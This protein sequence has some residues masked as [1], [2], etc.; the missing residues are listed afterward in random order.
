MAL[1]SAKT[2]KPKELGM[3]GIV[4][5]RGG[6]VKGVVNDSTSREVHSISDALV[7]AKLGL[8]ASDDRVW[9][10]GIAVFYRIFK[11]LENQCLEKAD[12]LDPRLL[13]IRIPGMERTERFEADLEFYYGPE[14]KALIEPTSPEI[15]AYI[16]HLSKLRKEEPIV[17]S[18]F[19]YHLYMGLFA[20]GQILKR[21]RRI[22][23]KV[24]KWLGGSPGAGA[25]DSSEGLEVVSFGSP[26]LDLKRA[27]RHG[28]E[29]LADELDDKSKNRILEEGINVFKLNNSIIRTIQS[30]DEVFQQRL[31][32][33]SVPVIVAVLGPRGMVSDRMV[34]QQRVRG[35]VGVKGRL[36][37]RKGG[38]TVAARLGIDLRN[39]IGKKSVARDTGIDLRD[40]IGS[41]DSAMRLNTGTQALRRPL[42]TSKLITPVLAAAVSDLHEPQFLRPRQKMT[43]TLPKKTELIKIRRTVDN[44]IPPGKLLFTVKNSGPAKFEDLTINRDFQP[45]KKKR[46][47]EMEVD[48][49]EESDGTPPPPPRPKPKKTLAKAQP[50][51][52]N[53]MNCVRVSSLP[54]NLS[55]RDI[56]ELFDDFGD[57]CRVSKKA[58]TVFEVEFETEDDA[59]KAV[60]ECMDVT[61]DGKLI[62]V[63]LVPSNEARPEAR[64]QGFLSKMRRVG[65][66]KIGVILKVK[67]ASGTWMPDAGGSK[68]ASKMPRVLERGG[69]QRRYN[70]DYLAKS[71]PEVVYDAAPK[72]LVRNVVTAQR[73]PEPPKPSSPVAVPKPQPD[74]EWLKTPLKAKISRGKVISS[75]MDVDERFLD[76]LTDQGDF[77][78]IGCIGPEGV[79]KSTILNLVADSSFNINKVK[80]QKTSS[81]RGVDGVVTAE[82]VILLDFEPFMSSSALVDRMWG[83][84]AGSSGPAAGKASFQKRDDS[85]IETSLDVQSL[86][87]AALALMTCHIV[88]VVQDRVL[89]PAVVSSDKRTRVW[90]LNRDR[91]FGKFLEKISGF[92]HTVEML[93]QRRGVMAAEEEE[94]PNQVGELLKWVGPHGMKPFQP[95]V[96]FIHNRCQPEDFTSHRLSSLHTNSDGDILKKQLGKLT[97]S[98]HD[99]LRCLRIALWSTPRYPVAEQFVTEKNCAASPS[100]D[101]VVLDRGLAEYGVGVDVLTE[102]PK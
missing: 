48:D 99:V 22:V 8:S 62:D 60:V 84:N 74:V 67:S 46:P 78:V 7:N 102:A 11:F 37:I 53:S 3:K 65:V 47:M 100:A 88:M 85:L 36:G 21:K 33:F 91:F 55:T 40:L 27:L 63:V 87:T 75:G 23:Q 1:F 5:M 20:G 6:R 45:K 94:N 14:W 19:V 25:D 92:L 96:I 57:I 10:E 18:S 79:G 59:R 49:D 34:Q 77:L 98:F 80:L 61:L 13:K 71:R 73:A 66:V 35:A 41:D 50:K 69:G 51:S 56:T 29:N 32:S 101:S 83:K 38:K 93:R 76:L 16:E 97:P 44:I 9:K 95:H 2:F 15:L 54:E 68:N 90:V 72:L 4:A 31:R 43:F 86:Q 89:D 52:S 26:I 70:G 39:K 24:P 42:R 58:S 81:T 64:K 28:M 82:R 30:A 17:L 12:S